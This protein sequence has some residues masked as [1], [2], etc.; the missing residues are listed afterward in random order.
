MR[1]IKPDFPAA[2]GISIRAILW[3]AGYSTMSR[4]LMPPRADKSPKFK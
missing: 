3:R 4:R 2:P 1:P